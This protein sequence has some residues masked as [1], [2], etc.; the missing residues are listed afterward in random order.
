MGGSFIEQAMLLQDWWNHVVQG[1]AYTL[2]KGP[3]IVTMHLP[4]SNDCGIFTAAV[5][6]D[7]AADTLCRS[8][9]EPNQTGLVKRWLMFILVRGG[10][11]GEA[12]H[13]SRV[14]GVVNEQSGNEGPAGAPQTGSL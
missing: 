1:P 5:M 9:P 14:R 11:S 3:G 13:V 4:E 10:L 12:R 8:L 2:V 7:Q 6:Y